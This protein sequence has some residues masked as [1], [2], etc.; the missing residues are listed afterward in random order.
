MSR[1]DNIHSNSREVLGTHPL[2]AAKPVRD[3]MS[4]RRVRPSELVA[5]LLAG[6]PGSEGNGPLP[7][8]PLDKLGEHVREIKRNGIRAVKVFSMARRKDA[9]AS[10]ALDLNNLALAAIKTIK[11]ATP[12]LCVITDT[13]LC[14]YTANGDCVL[15]TPE[16]VPDVT[17]S[18]EIL[19][20]QAL[21]QAEAGADIIGPAPVAD[22]AVAA[23]RQRLD[24]NG[25]RHVPTM[26]HLTFRSALYRGY[27]NAMRTGSG[28]QRQGFQIDPVRSDQY[29]AMAR[30]LVSE[31][32]D[33]LMIQPSLF[34]GDLIDKV[35]GESKCMTGVFSVSGEYLMFK[36]ASGS[37]DILLEHAT[38]AIRAGADFVVSYGALELAR[39]I[40]ELGR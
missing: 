38:G 7:T 11:D 40:N 2:R 14:G 8:I 12:D 3:F 9:N 25:K 18:F 23:I 17:R 15:R 16:G 33:I 19:S 21:M 30:C 37:E 1:H 34:S 6:E 31:G 22:G 4:A 5:A 10:E 13:C 24:S 39:F 32:A 35:K 28:E 20:A 29:L 36:S 27:R 26:P